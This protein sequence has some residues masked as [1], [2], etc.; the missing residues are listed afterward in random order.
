MRATGSGAPPKRPTKNGT[1]AGKKVPLA[2]RGI[3]PRLLLTV[4]E[5]AVLLGFGRSKVQA[6]VQRGDMPSIKIGKWRRVSR[7]A[8]DAIRQWRYRP[9]YLNGTPVEVDT[10]ITVNFV[11]QR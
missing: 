1:A 2:L 3:E 7:A 11:L 6:L 9:Y 5:V 8:L 10:E 4:Q